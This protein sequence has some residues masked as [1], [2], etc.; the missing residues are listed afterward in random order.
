MGSGFILFV[1]MVNE[2]AM[3]KTIDGAESSILLNGYWWYKCMI[4]TKKGIVHIT[5]TRLT[6]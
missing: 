5:V 3:A 1:E 2:L 6:P 4:C